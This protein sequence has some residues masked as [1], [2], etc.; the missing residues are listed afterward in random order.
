MDLFLKR[1]YFILKNWDV[2]NLENKDIFSILC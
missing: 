2:P 1:K